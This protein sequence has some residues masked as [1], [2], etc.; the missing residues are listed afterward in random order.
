MTLLCV[1]T[2][3][4]SLLP[5]FEG[6]DEINFK[7]CVHMYICVATLCDMDPLVWIFHDVEPTSLLS[8]NPLHVIASLSLMNTTGPCDPHTMP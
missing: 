7:M 4:Y 6:F 3:F 8:R 5:P 1:I 2:Y